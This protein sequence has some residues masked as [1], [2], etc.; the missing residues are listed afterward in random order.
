MK[1]R[2]PGDFFG[3]RQ[4]GMPDFAIADIF[5][6]SK[7]LMD[8]KE[9]REILKRDYHEEMEQ[10]QKALISKENFTYIDFHS[11]CL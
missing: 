4:S 6:D 7:E 5:T 11:I 10:I 3:L 8:A 9:V 1:Q 2:G